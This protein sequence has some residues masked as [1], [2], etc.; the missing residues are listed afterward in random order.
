VR[1]QYRLTDE[2]ASKRAMTSIMGWDI[3]GAHVKACLLEAGEVR[4]AQQVPCALWK[5][6]EHLE[7]A[8]HEL[9][10]LAK[11]GA[12]ALH[13]V[14]MTGEL[15][16]LFSSRAQG[17]QAIVNCVEQRLPHTH[18]FA[19]T[20]GFL[21]AKQACENTEAVASANWFATA[22]YLAA[23]STAQ[24]SEQVLLD[25]GSTTTDIVAVKAG[26][27][28]AVGVD[29]F[30]RLT[31]DELVYTGC[32]RTPLMAL[33]QRVNFEGKLVN[34]MAEYFATTADIYRI[35]G[36]LDE[37]SDQHAA[38]DNAEKTAHASA[39]RMARM[40]GRDV[41]SA[42]AN[43]WRKLAEEFAQAQTSLI[44]AALVRVWERAKLHA[45]S[46]VLTGSGAFIGEKVAAQLGLKSERLS[47][48]MKTTHI[49]HADACAPAI[50]TAWLMQSKA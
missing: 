25:I 48:L 9:L 40:I 18:F 36:E 41:D 49:A 20:Q 23:S 37:A 38:A 1:Y 32:A 7:A 21:A 12:D 50:A 30:T 5:G 2:D 4:W 27:I 10:E 3:G 39:R 35:T 33:A 46:L 34:V 8:I 22:Q 26:E 31:N 16:D 45:P 43:D 13:A 17:V 14:T 24:Q 11:P 29:D 44:S 28:L 19:G 42:A 47:V 6:M 15:V